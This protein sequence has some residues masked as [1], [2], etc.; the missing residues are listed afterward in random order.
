[1]QYYRDYKPIISEELGV[2]PNLIKPRNIYKINSYKYID[3]KTKSLAGNDTSLVFVIGVS[4]DKIISGIKINMIK[5]DIFYRWF[6]KLFQKGLTEEAID[7]SEDLDELLILDNKD[8]KKI[9][10]QFIQPTAFYR[11]E[12][13]VYRTY[14]QKSIKSIEEIKIK[15]EVLKKI[16]K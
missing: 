8:G 9:F 13:S 5:P 10:T 12:P 15:K 11:K 3:G 14:I 7:N 4:P 6:K 1:M 2:G 16:Y